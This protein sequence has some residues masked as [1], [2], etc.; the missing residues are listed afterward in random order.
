[1]PPFS[2]Q[3]IDGCTRAAHG[4]R[5]IVNKQVTREDR[6]AAV[7][8]NQNGEMQ[9][10]TVIA[11]V[12]AIACFVLLLLGFWWVSRKPRA[13]PTPGGG[14]CNDNPQVYRRCCDFSQWFFLRRARSPASPPHPAAEVPITVHEPAPRL[15]HVGPSS[16]HAHIPEE[17]LDNFHSGAFELDDEI[18]DFMFRHADRTRLMGEDGTVTVVEGGVA[19]KTEKPEDVIVTTTF[20]AGGDG[21]TQGGCARSLDV[22]ENGGVDVAGYDTVANTTRLEATQ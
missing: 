8:G 5:Y 20:R 3:V 16:P 19:E 22:V 14:R 2:R 12:G 21:Y 18:G 4:S 15:S 1:M 17:T 9:M 13:P 10:K 11:I 7:Q 6:E